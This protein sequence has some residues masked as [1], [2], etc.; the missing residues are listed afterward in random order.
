MAQFRRAA[1]AQ[2]RRARA[3]YTWIITLI[4]SEHIRVIGR[5]CSK[6]GVLCDVRAEYMQ[7]NLAALCIHVSAATEFAVWT[8]CVTRTGGATLISPCGPCVRRPLDKQ[9]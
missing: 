7:L 1:I 2:F 3:F 6:P 9:L 4:A 8:S 5:S